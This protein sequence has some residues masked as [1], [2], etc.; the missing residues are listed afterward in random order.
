MSLAPIL[1]RAQTHVKR[2]QIDAALKIY[3]GLLVTFPNHPQINTEVG[4]LLLHHRPAQEA[5]KP[6]EKAVSALPNARELCVCLLVAHQRCGN[7]KRAREVLAQMYSQGFEPSS[8]TQFEQELNE[9]PREDLEALKKMVSQQQWVNAEIA[10]RMMVNDY[11][12]SATAQACLSRVLAAET[13][14]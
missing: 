14:R 4:V 6:L 11:P 2:G 8:L 9:P 7:L 3:K 12:A 13:A 1:L 10:A 5:I